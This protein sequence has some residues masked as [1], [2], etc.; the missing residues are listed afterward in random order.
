MRAKRYF[1][2]P[3]AILMIALPALSVGCKKAPSAGS[4]TVVPPVLLGPENYVVVSQG[5][6]ETG[7]TISGSLA[8]KREASV[9]AQVGGAVLQTYVEQG[10]AVS[11]GTLLA[12]LDDRTL[13]SAV[14]SAQSALTNAKNTL[15][16][17]KRDEDRQV[18][19]LKA[20]A[21]AERDVDNAKR[22]TISAQA[23]E[24]QAESQLTSAQKQ[25]TYTQ[26][27]APFAGRVSDK[28]VS[29]GD[30]V[31]PGAAMY[32]VVD[33]SSM[34]LEASIAADQLSL[35]HPGDPVEF[36]VTGYPDRTFNGRITRINPTADPATRQVR[37]Y[38][39]LPNSGSNLV[40]ALYAEGHIA[41]KVKNAITVPS[42]AVDRKLMHP[43]LFRVRNGVVER[44]E[45]TI[46]L[47]DARTDRVEVLSG[48]TL[49]DTVL[50][51]AALSTPAG[52]KVQLAPG[53]A[54]SGA[55][56]SAMNGSS[57]GAPEQ[58]VSSRATPAGTAPQGS[59]SQGAPAAG[60]VPA[61]SVPA[62]S[63]Q[64]SGQSGTKGGQR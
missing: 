11:E 50:M 56:P 26:V 38:A 44:V 20:G 2:L 63:A 24:A 5:R 27:R 29:T 64:G 4:S 55:A 21:I 14:E 7:P 13:R 48:V 19:L 60:N 34:E 57:G 58:S 39:E 41:T 25:L 45:V 54:S 18:A 10:Q 6:I 47:A 62:S 1:S 43:A 9:R 59:Q 15:A 3:A 16:V 31:Q 40:G 33:P 35:I 37:V 52:T 32:T 51:G 30:I 12:Q 23:A 42:S 8:P 28:L 17:A 49:G 46:G 36:H 61:S 53:T 22:A